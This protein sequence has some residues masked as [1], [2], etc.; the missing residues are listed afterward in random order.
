MTVNAYLAQR[1]AE[2]MG[3]VIN[4][5]TQRWLHHCRVDDDA[6]RAAY[7]CDVIYGTNNE[8][9][10]DYLRDTKFR[11]RIWFSAIFISRLLMKLTRS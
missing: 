1:D 3:R 8:F 7:G 10:F 2:W 4:F 9:G 6:R 11:L 5:G